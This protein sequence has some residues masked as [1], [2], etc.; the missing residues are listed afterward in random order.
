MQ[1]IKRFFTGYLLAI[2]V[3]LSAAAA[4]AITTRM[5]QMA[6][7]SQAATEEGQFLLGW[8]A[9]V[10]HVAGVVL[11]GLVM[12]AAAKRG[13]KKLAFGMGTIVIA[14]AIFSAMSIM[15]FMAS[16]AL[17][18]TK[19][20]EAQIEQRSL[21]SEARRK[22]AEKRLEIQA[23]LAEKALGLN[24]VDVKGKGIGR[25]ER[26]DIRKSN[27]EGQRALIAEI[28]KAEAHKRAVGEIW[29]LLVYR[30]HCEAA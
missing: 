19:S 10:V 24:Q 2:L 14:S 16:E 5:N 13:Y 27:Q 23:K 30:A 7:V 9:I 6:G 25:E 12:G 28:G 4:L 20:R 3:G 17:S 8:A 21:D 11:C 22:A 26:K 18:V 29:P 15:G 1:A